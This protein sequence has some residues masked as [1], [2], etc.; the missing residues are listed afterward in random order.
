MNKEQFQ[1][2]CLDVRFS[3]GFIARGKQMYFIGAHIGMTSPNNAPPEDDE[4]AQSGYRV[5]RQCHKRLK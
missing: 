4:L 1:Q 3:E 5:G 2:F